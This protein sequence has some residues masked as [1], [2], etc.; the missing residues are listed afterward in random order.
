MGFN[1]DFWYQPPHN[2]MISSEWAAPRTFAPG[3]NFDDVKAGKYGRKIHVWDWKER[4]IRQS[5]D[6]GAGS[7]PLEVRFAH[8]PTKARVLL[9]LHSAARCGV[10]LLSGQKVDREKSN[11]VGGS[12]E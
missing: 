8:D 9:E 7:I 11:R 1:Y 6:L 4:K 2:R 3:P 12:Q 10:S 5:L